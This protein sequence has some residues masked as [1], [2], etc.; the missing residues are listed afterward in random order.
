MESKEV[1]IQHLKMLASS[2]A[3]SDWAKQTI[4]R[5][6]SYMQQETAQ[7]ISTEDDIPSAT[8]IWR[9]RRS[10]GGMSPF[11]RWIGSYGNGFEN[12][13]RDDIKNTSEYR[14]WLG[15]EPTQEQKKNTPWTKEE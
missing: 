4:I 10:D 5:A 11:I 7:L 6:V 3:I 8:I 14:F 9:E 1:V 12:L 13:S 2:P 15:G